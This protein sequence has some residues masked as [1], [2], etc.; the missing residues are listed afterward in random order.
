MTR[1]KRHREFGHV[2]E[3]HCYSVPSSD[4][5]RSPANR[6]RNWDVEPNGPVVEVVKPVT[7]IR[8][9][10]GLHFPIGEIILVKVREEHGPINPVRVVSG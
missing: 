9:S 1:R 3:Q 7:S 10:N 8:E 4:E 2:G 6:S 5:V